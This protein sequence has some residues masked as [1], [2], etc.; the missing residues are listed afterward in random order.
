MATRSPRCLTYEV[1]ASSRKDVVSLLQ[2][3]THARPHVQPLR[4]LQEHAH[5]SQGW[6]GRTDSFL[7][8]AGGGHD[9]IGWSH[10]TLTHTCGVSR[11]R[12][13]S[14][15][16]PTPSRVCVSIFSKLPSFR[17]TNGF[18]TAV[19]AA[20]LAASLDANSGN[21]VSCCATI[22]NPSSARGRRRQPATAP[23]PLAFQPRLP[24]MGHA[25]DVA[26]GERAPLLLLEP[27]LIPTKAVEVPAIMRNTAAPGTMVHDGRDLR[28]IVPTPPGKSGESA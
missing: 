14:S 4:L 25:D 15:A 8:R 3:F 28:G 11:V 18:A 13:P 10:H 26:D 17:L 12:M 5:S 2:P 9:R 7:P 20:V 22:L 24:A 6:N 27:C 16:G 1:K 21:C 23:S 19:P